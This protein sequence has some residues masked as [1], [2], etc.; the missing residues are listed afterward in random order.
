MYQ[1]NS[2]NVFL[3]ESTIRTFSTDENAEITYF[4]LILFAIEQIIY[5]TYR[6][7]HFTV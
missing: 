4:V 1:L 7:G 5:R 2:I 6:Q 3:K